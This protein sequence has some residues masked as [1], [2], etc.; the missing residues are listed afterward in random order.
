MKKSMSLLKPISL[1]IAFSL[2]AGSL[3]AAI[4]GTY[5][6]SNASP[7]G[8]D[9]EWDFSNFSTVSPGTISSNQLRVS[10]AL[11]STLTTIGEFTVTNNTGALANFD[12]ADFDMF[13]GTAGREWTLSLFSS[14]DSYTTALGTA[15]TSSNSSEDKTISL[16]GLSLADSASLT[17][18]IS[19]QATGAASGDRFIR[20][21]NFAVAVV[22]EPSSLLLSA[23]GLGFAAF[24]L[25]RR[26]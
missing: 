10:G 15:I 23:L 6:F 3:N 1:A 25:R 8:V 2:F 11:P 22:P 24:V 4:I 14:A 12:F 18:R 16:A 20:V 5:A 7:S 21:D 13:V 17:F 19:G 26:R 9:A